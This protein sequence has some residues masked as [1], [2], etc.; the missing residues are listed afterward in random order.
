MAIIP[1]MDYALSLIGTAYIGWAP[2][3]P[4]YDEGPSF[5]FAQG[6]PPPAQEVRK[7][8]VCCAGLINLMRRAVGLFP[9]GTTVDYEA[10][11]RDKSTPYDPAVEYPIGTLLGRPFHDVEDQGHVAVVIAPGQV[12]HSWTVG[13]V[14]ISEI[15]PDYYTWSCPPEAYLHQ[16]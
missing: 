13:G 15:V 12:L 2:G 7:K 14:Q 16:E 5:W 4:L 8:G 10:Y 11:L 1:Q 3:E 6:P 9:I